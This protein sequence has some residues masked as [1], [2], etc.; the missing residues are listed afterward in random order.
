[1][2]GLPGTWIDTWRSQ[3]HNTCRKSYRSMS[4]KRFQVPT[5]LLAVPRWNA[6]IS[7]GVLYSSILAG[8]GDS[9][10]WSAY[11]RNMVESLVSP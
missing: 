10:V 4:P 7:R 8:P 9:M 6:Q 3:H 11:I 5:P 2:R 1:M